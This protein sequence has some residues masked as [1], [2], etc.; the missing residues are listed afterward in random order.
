[1]QEWQDMRATLSPSFTGNKLRIMFG[2]M[3]DCTKQL[4]NY[5]QKQDGMVT[6]EMKDTFRRLAN[7]LIATTAF[8]ITCD[9]LK[10]PENEFFIMGRDVT[11]FTGF[12]SLLFLIN[13]F[14]SVFMKLFNIRIIQEKASA[15][16][17]NII[18]ESIKYRNEKGIVRP[19][20]IHLLLEARRSVYD[21]DV[22]NNNIDN[23]PFC[24]IA[25]MEITDDDITAQALVFFLAGFDTA[26]T[27][28]TFI[29]YELAVNSGI[30]ERLRE[31]IN[32]NSESCDGDIT[33]EVLVGM[34]YLDMVIS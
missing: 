13:G 8:G 34:K 20:M 17:S 26:S 24:K 15:F 22:Q 25:K 19:D 11:D 12:R 32:R 27:L 21:T 9:S 14:S 23:E 10:N 31:E 18:K 28:M 3:K 4:I 16:F 1:G 30:Q 2:L 7:D 33:F 29:C 5:F 6:V